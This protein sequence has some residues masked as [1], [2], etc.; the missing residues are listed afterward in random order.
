L[1]ACNHLAVFACSKAGQPLNCHRAGS[2][3]ASL[4]AAC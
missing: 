4:L 1:M 3:P 2:S